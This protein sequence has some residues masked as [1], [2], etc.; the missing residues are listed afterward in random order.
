MA[1]AVCKA[2][3]IATRNSKGCRSE[4]EF[5]DPPWLFVW[6]C[7][8]NQGPCLRELSLKDNFKSQVIGLVSIPQELHDIRVSLDIWM[9]RVLKMSLNVIGHQSF[10]YHD[11][12]KFRFA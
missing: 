12:A 2:M 1:S 7:S 10:E 9:P 8:K 5:R 11:L 6:Q 4:D 3:P